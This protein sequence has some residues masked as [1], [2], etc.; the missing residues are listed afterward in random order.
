MNSLQVFS[1]PEFGQVR[2]L[3]I[4][5]EPWFVGKDVAEILGYTNPQKAIRDH[6][7]DEDRTV[8]ESFTVNGTKA[9]LINE[10]GL[11]SLILSSKLT[12]A[13]KFKRWVTSEVLPAIRKSGYYAAKPKA[14]NLREVIQLAQLT[15][16]TMLAQ[17]CS[18]EDIARAVK[19]VCEQYHVVLPE[20]FVKPQST[21]LED[22]YDMVNYIFACKRGRGYRKPSYEDF[23]AW[24]CENL[25]LGDG[26]DV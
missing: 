7:D 2:T 13:K 10:S 19:E 16:E 20:F 18:S 25:M 8:N 22:I 26:E 24:R 4:D 11:Y 6:V 3:T 12:T 21:K 15:K 17:N 1:N 9:V 23:V 14:R 5:N